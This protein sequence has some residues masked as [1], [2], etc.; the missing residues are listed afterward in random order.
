VAEWEGR[1]PLP[2]FRDYLRKKKLLDEESE[3]VVETEIRQEIDTA[4]EK[5]E[6][7]RPDPYDMFKYVYQEMTPELQR[8]MAELK[9]HLEGKAAAT[10]PAVER[11]SRVL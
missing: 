6:K 7:Y 1:D 11:V 5:Y 3:K 4:T 9:E 8:Q 10:A 2:R